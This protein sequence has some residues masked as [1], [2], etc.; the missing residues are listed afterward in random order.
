MNDLY[1]YLFELALAGMIGVVTLY[2]KSK[3]SEMKERADENRKRIEDL[4]NNMSVDVTSLKGLTDAVKDH[5]TREE[6]YWHK[7]DDLLFTNERAHA[8]FRERMARIE[9]KVVNGL[10]G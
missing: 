9:A 10:K 4:E 7:I 8:D 5:T 1:R 2:F 3:V 6:S